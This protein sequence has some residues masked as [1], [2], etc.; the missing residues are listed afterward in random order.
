MEKV[1]TTKKK[2]NILLLT[3]YCSDNE[4]NCSNEKPCIDCL[5]MC[6]IFKVDEIDLKEYVGTLEYLRS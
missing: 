3:S 4:T 1:P 5:S 2:R 6:N